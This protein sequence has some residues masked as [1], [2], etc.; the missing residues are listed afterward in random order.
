MSLVFQDVLS[1]ED[2][3]GELWCGVGGGGEIQ[4][5]VKTQ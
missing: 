1:S 3:G 5:M 2:N 4:E